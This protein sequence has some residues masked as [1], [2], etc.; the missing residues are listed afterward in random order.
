M[1]GLS[2]TPDPS[3]CRPSARPIPGF[4]V[5]LE[6]SGGRPEPTGPILFAVAQGPN[7]VIVN[8]SEPMLRSKTS[9]WKLW[10]GTVKVATKAVST[11][12]A[13]PTRAR[14]IPTIT[15]SST[16]NSRGCRACRRSFACSIG[17]MPRPPGSRE[18]NPTRPRCISP[19]TAPPS[20]MRR[21][22]RNGRTWE[23][24]KKRRSTRSWPSRSRRR[25][26]RR[27]RV[28]AQA[29]HD[30]PRVQGFLPP[31]RRI[32]FSD[33]SKNSFV[34]GSS[35]DCDVVLRHPS[36]DPLHCGVILERGSVLVWDLGAQS[37]IKVK[38][39][40][41]EQDILKVGRRD[42]ARAWW[43]CAFAFSCAGRR[44]SPRSPPRSTRMRRSR[45]PPPARFRRP[46]P[47]P[48]RRSARLRKVI[49]KGPI[50]YEKVAKQLRQTGKGIPF[51]EKLGSLFG[52]KK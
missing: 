27:C 50:T 36:V 1:P 38:R 20:F 31:S 28:R 18:S 9:V 11:S 37:G 48:C 45:W 43:N 42:D 6:P 47:C 33:A 49:P 51:L 39:R 30:L 46:A 22:F 17:A 7:T 14:F 52:K 8:K 16:P 5:S 29:L 3:R 15:S 41:V 25:P 24:R 21:I 12:G 19:W 40:P 10:N 13:A 35:E 2:R 26:N 32:Y 34:I 4:A 23:P 44:S